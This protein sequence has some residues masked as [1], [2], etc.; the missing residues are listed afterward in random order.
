M[1][2]IILGLLI[3]SS[4]YANDFSFTL[5]QSEND[6]KLARSNTDSM[7]F[8]VNLEYDFNPNAYLLLGYSFTD[9]NTDYLGSN[10]YGTTINS[11][12]HSGNSFLIGIGFRF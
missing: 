9:G 12:I 4:T 6:D 7:T 10:K 1:K 3:M 2:K 11:T 5:E 8:G